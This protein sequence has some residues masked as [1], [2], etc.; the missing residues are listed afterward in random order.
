MK[1]LSIYFSLIK[2]KITFTVV[3]TSFIGFYLASLVYG[4]TSFEPLVLNLLATGLVCAGACVLNHILEVRSD[5]KM[6]RTKNRPLPQKVISLSEAWLLAFILIAGGAA[7]MYWNFKPGLVIGSLITCFLY[8]GIYTPLKK[9]TWWNTSIGAIPGAL[10]V[11][12]GWYAVSGKIELPG[13]LFFLI[14]FFW[15]HPHFYAIAWVCRDDYQEGNYKMI[16]ENDPKGDKTFS[17][18]LIHA[19][20]LFI[21]SLIIPFH[22][23]FQDVLNNYFYFIAVIILGFWFIYEAYLA[24]AKRSDSAS[25]RLIGSSIFYLPLFFLIILLD[26]NL[27]SN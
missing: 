14:I 16:T 21:V 9:I 26:V 8:L 27:I 18:S 3:F 15:Q 2:I 12:G 23:S 24:Y 25:R 7:I 22:P 6:K 10:P 1:R 20:F 19:F 17:H 11:L 5:K 13:I 4:K